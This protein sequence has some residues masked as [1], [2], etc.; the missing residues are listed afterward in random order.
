MTQLTL[1]VGES[2]SG[3]TS[4]LVKELSA[5]SF[6]G[7]ITPG[8]FEASEKVG[9][10]AW[11]LSGAQKPVLHLMLAR[12]RDLVEHI[13][14]DDA[15]LGWVF[16]PEAIARVNEHLAHLLDLENS[17]YNLRLAESHSSLSASNT[18]VIDELGPLEFLFGK[19][20]KVALDA[21]DAAVFQ[22]VLLAI[23]P[24]LVEAARSR[25]QSRYDLLKTIEP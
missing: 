3:K 5:A 13:P 20:F 11:L 1:L 10:E 17:W 14:D 24:S 21:I 4:L 8:V 23:R 22:N 6:V 19:G 7:V 2:G 18:L 12:R 16:D 15:G 25:W 9:I